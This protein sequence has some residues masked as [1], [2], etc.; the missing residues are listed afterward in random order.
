VQGAEQLR[1]FVLR[2]HA[3]IIFERDCVRAALDCR[4]RFPA[5]GV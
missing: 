2:F 1:F 3:D 4:R 5:R